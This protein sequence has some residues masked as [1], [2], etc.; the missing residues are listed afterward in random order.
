MHTIYDLVEKAEKIFSIRHSYLEDC[1][2]AGLDGG[3]WT[4]LLV[5]K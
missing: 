1:L 2:H 4:S 5:N 3:V